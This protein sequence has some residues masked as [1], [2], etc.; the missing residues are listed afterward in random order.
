MPETSTGVAGPASLQAPAAV[1]GQTADTAEGT[2]GNEEVAYPDVAFLHQHA[3]HGAAAGLHF[4]LDHRAARG[5]SEISGQAEHAGLQFEDFQQFGDAFAG[6]GRH[7][8]D[9]GFAAPGRGVEPVLRQFAVDALK[10]RIAVLRGHHVD[11]VEGHHHRHLGCLGVGDGFDGLGHQAV[12]G[13]HQQHH[14]IG[15]FRAAGA[16]RGEGGVA[17]RVEEHHGFRLAVGAFHR[18]AVGTDMLGDA[19]VFVRGHIGF[20]D[21]VQERGFAM[22][23]MAQNGDDRRTRENLRAL[24]V[25]EFLLHLDRGGL[26]GLDF[27]FNVVVHGDL[28]GGLG[29]DGRVHGGHDAL[30]EQEFHAGRGL[31]AGGGGERLDRDGFLDGHLAADIGRRLRL[32]V[33]ATA[34][35]LAALLHES[36]GTLEACIQVIQ[37]RLRELGRAGEHRAVAAAAA[38]RERTALVLF[39]LG[40]G[41]AGADGFGL[42]TA[43][44][45]RAGRTGNAGGAG[46]SRRTRAAAGRAAGGRAVA[47]VAGTGRRTRPHP[48]AGANAVRECFR[49]PRC[50]SPADRAG[51]AWR[52]WPSVRPFAGHR[53]DGSARFECRPAADADGPGAVAQAGAAQDG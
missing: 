32:E 8:A 40:R 45:H 33:A 52:G 36:R 50:G 29:V 31:D 39:I 9:F 42:D 16:H 4:A 41:I 47:A 3:R 51:C 2:A 18:D 15:D 7:H 46:R 22:V 19:A 27:E 23:D 43:A 6:P 49:R 20:A 25:G 12:F 17:G 30:L 48:G 34:E 24:A 14:H 1:V 38:G 26:V 10:Q 13:R 5:T 11:L 44:A 53:S 28:H 21:A 37:V 35:L